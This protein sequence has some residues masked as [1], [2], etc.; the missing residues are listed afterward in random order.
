MNALHPVHRYNRQTSKHLNNF[1]VNYAKFTTNQFN[2][3][4]QVPK[5]PSGGVR[6]C[7]RQCEL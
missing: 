5:P 2:Q 7:K 6:M 1:V 4:P 3:F